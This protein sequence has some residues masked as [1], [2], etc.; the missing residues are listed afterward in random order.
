MYRL[1]GDG[2]QF[3]RTKAPPIINGSKMNKN[4]QTISL[5]LRSFST[6]KRRGAIPQKP[7]TKIVDHALKRSPPI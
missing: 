2:L 1:K 6:P 4:S 7:K 5:S 3:F